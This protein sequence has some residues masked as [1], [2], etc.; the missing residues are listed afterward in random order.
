M[1]LQYCLGWK[2]KVLYEEDRARIGS[3]LMYQRMWNSC[4][5]DIFIM[6][7]DMLPTELEWMDNLLY[8][9]NKYPEAGLFGCKLIYPIADEFENNFLQSAGG[10]FNEEH[11]PQHYGSGLEVSTQEVFKELETDTGQYDSVREVA[12]STFGGIYIRREVLDI[13][14]DF[15]P[16]FEWSY[17][18]DVDYCLTA[19]KKGWK[20]YQVPVTLVHYESKDNK[21]LRAVNPEL[22]EKENRN[23]I[24]L[25][26]KWNGSSLFETIERIVE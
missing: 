20:V 24:R 10:W 17:N 25:Q 9:V 7:A 8:Y 15:D 22:T 1:E 26:N 6:H 16:S 11:I 23:L 2:F 13:V 18:R 14:G 3:D 5:T 12:W 21:R 19:R 4:N